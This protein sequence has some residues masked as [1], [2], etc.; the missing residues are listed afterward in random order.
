MASPSA[1]TS[2]YVPRASP[3][4]SSLASVLAAECSLA[5]KSGLTNLLEVQ[6]SLSQGGRR[7]SDIGDPH[8]VFQASNSGACFP[9]S[10]NGC[11]G[12]Y[13]IIWSKE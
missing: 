12:M 11:G 4:S 6:S 5:S 2:S 7:G 9:S 1:P 3:K 8:E 13:L 10:V